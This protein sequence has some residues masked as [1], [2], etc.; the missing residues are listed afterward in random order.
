MKKKFPPKKYLFSMQLFIVDTTIFFKKKNSHEN[1]KK[2]PSKLAY[3]RA[4]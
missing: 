3:N 2:T 1:I 4:S